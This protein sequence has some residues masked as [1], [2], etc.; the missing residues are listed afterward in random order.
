MNAKQKEDTVV[1][2][3]MALLMLLT[4]LTLTAAACTP[5]ADVTANT[6]TTTPQAQATQGTDAAE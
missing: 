2:K 1:K 3:M 4:L 6:P 5:A